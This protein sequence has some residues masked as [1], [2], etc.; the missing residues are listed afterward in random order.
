MKNNFSIRF[1][2]LSDTKDI[3]SIYNYYIEETTITFECKKPSLDEFKQRIKSI[4]NTYA[5]LVCAINN[6]VIGY[7]Y[8]SRLRN[9]EAYQWDAE[10]SIYLDK[11]YTN[12]GI[13]KILYLALIDILKLQNIY[14]I[15]GV[16]TQ[17][18]IPSEKLHE[19]IGFTKIGIFHN[20]GNKFNKW[21]DVVWY[22]K[23]IIKFENTP[24]PL[25]SINEI[26]NNKADYI[27]NYYNKKIELDLKNL[28]FS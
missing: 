25:L 21:L 2:N 23:N 3:S 8:A 24:Q 11:D 27:L 10:L 13:G 5:Y 19:N 26:D 22:E 15:Y 16:I 7:A 18:N 28:N 6:K 17:P 20:T 14:N 1:M 4:S 12:F 9:R